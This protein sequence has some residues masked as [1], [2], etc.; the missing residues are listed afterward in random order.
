[1]T[2]WQCSASAVLRA[3]RCHPP[4][5]FALRSANEVV[6]YGRLVGTAERLSQVILQQQQTVA[7]ATNPNAL[8]A[9]ASQP[10]HR[11]AFLT[12]P[13]PSYVYSLLACWL[14]RSVALPLSP[15][16]PPKAHASTL[17][18]AD[19]VIILSAPPYCETVLDIQNALSS[20]P[21]SLTCSE[22]LPRL[23]HLSLH[24]T[25]SDINPTDNN[26]P[27][28]ALPVAQPD[29][30]MIL[31]TSGTTGS[32]KG[33]VWTHQMLNFQ[34]RTMYN[35]WRWSPHDVIL[36]V[37]PL[38]H[39]HGI[40]NV[41]LT[42]LFAGAQCIM[43]TR[44]DPQQVWNAFCSDAHEKPTV[45]M[46]VPTMYQKL[47]QYY[48]TCS[49]R[50]CTKMRA[51]ASAMRL[52]VCGSAS[53]SK[54]DFDEWQQ[55]TGH[56]ILE[57]YGMTETGMILSNRYDRRIQGSLG[58]PFPQVQ[59]QVD[60]TAYD[61]PVSDNMRYVHGEL[62][63]KSPSVFSQYWNKPQHSLNAFNQSGWFKTGDVVRMHVDNYE[64]QMIGRA[65]VDIIKTGGYKVSAV[66]IECIIAESDLVSQCAVV[67]VSD[68]TL[69]QRIVCAVI[70]NH[71]VHHMDESK[72]CH[73]LLH[74]LEHRLPKYMTPREF[75]VVTH[76][77]RNALGKVQKQLIIRHWD[78]SAGG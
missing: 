58:Q 78:A 57:R 17:H 68:S 16:Y 10:L 54:S 51:A 64:C 62:L 2:H 12:P 18:D 53:L 77:P 34:L 70:P 71:H 27:Q 31:Y 4:D 7:T 26:Y 41:L 33:V 50:S 3:I 5:A 76:F 36:N 25:L 55:I 59:V 45:F 47:I 28:T 39:V 56:K 52:F 75:R 67:G 74:W 37:L 44:F 49:P 20:S 73:R 14:A 22:N 60:T 43:N 66:H 23:R 11:V 24:S 13:D 29:P 30:A 63:V 46:A 6:S 1:M 40:V 65:S 21:S 48:K 32:P 35:E 42:S 19:P 38:H 72:L 9:S 61:Q 8:H 15:L 69:G